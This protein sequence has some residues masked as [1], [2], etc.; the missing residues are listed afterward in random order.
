MTTNITTAT[1]LLSSSFYHTFVNLGSPSYNIRI[2]RP[3][4]SLSTM[5]TAPYYRTSTASRATTPKP[6]GTHTPPSCSTRQRNTS[7]RTTQT[8]NTMRQLVTR[9]TTRACSPS[10]ACSRRTGYTPTFLYLATSAATRS[11]TKTSTVESKP[12]V[13]NGQPTTL[14]SPW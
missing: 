10:L 14:T 12:G 1:N 5:P 6:T 2:P 11:P 3:Y 7:S 13:P 4:G 8:V 9:Y